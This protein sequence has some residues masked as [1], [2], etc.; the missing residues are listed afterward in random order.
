MSSFFSAQTTVINVSLCCY[1]SVY[2]YF[3]KQMA[4]TG[5]DHTHRRKKTEKKKE[6]KGRKKKGWVGGWVCSSKNS[7]ICL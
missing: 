7:P 2:V 3:N 1:I 5:H 4:V 6:K